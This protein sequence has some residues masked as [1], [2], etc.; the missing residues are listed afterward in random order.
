MASA[1]TKKEHWCRTEVLS[2]IELYKQQRC[3]WD[4]KS[5]EYKDREQRSAALSHICQE[6]SDSGVDVMVEDAK[7]KIDNIRCY[8]TS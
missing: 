8:R 6:L 7:K 1:L 5:S 4:I 3:L 2:L